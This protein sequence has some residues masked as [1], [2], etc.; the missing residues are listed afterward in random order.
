MDKYKLRNII[1][2]K[3][4]KGFYTPMVKLAE[5]MRVVDHSLL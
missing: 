5:I 4:I 1:Y 3:S 2:Q